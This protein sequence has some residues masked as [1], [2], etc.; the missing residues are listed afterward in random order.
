M[1]VRLP[2]GY[3]PVKPQTH[4]MRIIRNLIIGLV[5]LI[6]GVMLLMLIPSPQAPADKPWEVTVMPDGNSRVLGIHLGQTDSKPYNSS[7]AY[8]AQPVC[9]SIL[10]AAVAWKRILTV[11]IRRDCRPSWC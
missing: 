1:M 10:M 8:L 3:K 4:S 6:G 2:S 7:S 9:L 11:S 5:L